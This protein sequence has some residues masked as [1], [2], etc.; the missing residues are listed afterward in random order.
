[1]CF[2]VILHIEI[3]LYTH[4]YVYIYNIIYIFILPLQILDNYPYLQKHQ[5]LNLLL[6]FTTRHN[7]QDV[8]FLV[9]A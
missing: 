1:M 5:W 2:L 6:V 8:F 3:Y 4:K 9:I 7:N